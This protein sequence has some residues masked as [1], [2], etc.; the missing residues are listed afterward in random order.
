G[1]GQRRDR[2]ALQRQGLSPAAE[3]AGR[4]PLR[5]VSGDRSGRQQFRYLGQRLRRVATRSRRQQDRESCDHVTATHEREAMSIG[6]IGRGAMGAGI[7]PRLMAAGHTVTGWNRA[8][9]KAE[10]LVKAGMRF[11]DSPRAVA[12]TSDIV[13]SIVTDAAAVRE[14]ALGPD[15]V[16]AGL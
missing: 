1:R 2:R 7:V 6:F 5:R 15:G 3:A 4:P 14:T 13:F 8:R 10:P 9:A 11:A 16:I 12:A